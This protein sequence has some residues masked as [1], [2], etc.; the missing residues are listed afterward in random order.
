MTDFAI[1]QRAHQV[2]PRSSRFGP[3]KEC[4]LWNK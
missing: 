2:N 4:K 1:D 3:R